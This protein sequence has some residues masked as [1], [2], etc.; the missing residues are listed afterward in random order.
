MLTPVSITTKARIPVYLELESNRVIWEG[1][2]SKG[3]RIDVDQ[4][5]RAGLRAQLA[6]QSIVTG[7][8][9]VDLDFRPGVQVF[10]FGGENGVAEVPT[11]QSEYD[12]L[13]KK[14]EDVDVEASTNV[15]PW[16]LA[17]LRVTPVAV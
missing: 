10:R 6:P 15:S 5:V 4:M 14:L 16:R 2:K 7:Q 1:K 12:A 8:L 9:R 3:S 17:N 13:T 11:I